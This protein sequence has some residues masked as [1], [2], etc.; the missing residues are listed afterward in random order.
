MRTDVYV[1]IR[2]NPGLPH[3]EHRR[4]HYNSQAVNNVEEKVAAFAEN[5]MNT[6]T[7]CVAEYRD[8]LYHS[9]DTLLVLKR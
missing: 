6:Y 8:F 3:R 7:Q 1:I 9:M 2:S 5:R 4:V